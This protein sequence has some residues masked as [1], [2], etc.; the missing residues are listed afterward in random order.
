MSPERCGYSESVDITEAR[1]ILGQEVEQL[2]RATY[3]E[4]VG[5]L[6]DKTETYE[7][8]GG[9]GTHYQVELQAFWDDRPDKNLRVTASVDDGSARAFRPLSADFIRAPDGSF[10][11]E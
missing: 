9:S 7:R 11:G 4:L 5:R 2:R 8:R 1:S 3:D 10:V 6:L